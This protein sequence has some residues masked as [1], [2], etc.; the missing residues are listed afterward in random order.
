MRNPFRKSFTRSATIAALTA[1]CGL[2]IGGS[3]PSELTFAP[4]YFDISLARFAMWAR[5]YNYIGAKGPQMVK[6]VSLDGRF[7]SFP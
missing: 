6:F 7:V 4:R 2:S 3:P 1:A 5:E